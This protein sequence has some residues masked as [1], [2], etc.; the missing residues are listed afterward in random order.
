MIDQPVELSWRPCGDLSNKS[1]FLRKKKD[2]KDT[3]A[4]YRY[5]FFFHWPVVERFSSVCILGGG[6]VLTKTPPKAIPFLWYIT[7]HHLEICQSA[8]KIVKSF[9]YLALQ[10]Q[11][12][13]HIYLKAISGAAAVYL[14]GQQ[15]QC[16]FVDI[17]LIGDVIAIAVA[18]VSSA[19]ATFSSVIAPAHFGDDKRDI[20]ALAT[21]VGAPYGVPLYNFGTFLQSLVD[22]FVHVSVTGPAQNNIEY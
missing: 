8:P 5:S 2:R 1:R 12:I 4:N 11:I 15:V 21:F 17:P 14:L 19:T 22:S 18:Q 7:S 13:F 9:L 16:L 20:E 6:F 3:N 10:V